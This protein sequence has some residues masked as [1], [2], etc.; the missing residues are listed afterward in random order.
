MYLDLDVYIHLD[1]CIHLL[2][3]QAAGSLTGGW[4]RRP[5]SSRLLQ[6][7]DVHSGFL[8]ARPETQLCR[9]VRPLHFCIAVCGRLLVSPAAQGNVFGMVQHLFSVLF[10]NPFES[11][12][13]YL[14]K[15]ASS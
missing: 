6:L 14:P 2:S 4:L 3:K 9:S 8:C 15:E 7:V 5:V 11:C 12:Y 1:V 13:M 10:I